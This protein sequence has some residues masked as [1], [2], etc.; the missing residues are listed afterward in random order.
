MVVDAGIGAYVQVMSRR[1]RPT[2]YVEAVDPG[3]HG[4]APIDQNAR[5][6]LEA[7]GWRDPKSAPVPYEDAAYPEHWE[8]GNFA[9]EFPRSE[10]SNAI[11]EVLVE[12]LRRG[13]GVAADADLELRIFDAR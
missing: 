9:Q 11:A 5:D 12:T 4:H 8:G 2:T 7:L 3:H 1:D 6:A 13:Y 10:A